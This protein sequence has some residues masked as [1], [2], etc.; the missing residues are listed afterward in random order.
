MKFRYFVGIDVAKATL[1]I[2]VL[3]EDGSAWQEHIDN[4]TASIKE[5]LRLLQQDLKAG[6]KNTLFCLE[7]SGPYTGHLIGE[8]LRRKASLWVESALQIKRSLG[9]QRGKNDKIDALRIAQ[10]ASLKRASF[11]PFCP[12]REVMIRLQQ[13]SGLKHRLQQAIGS[14]Q[15]PIGEH[16]AFQPGHLIKK[17]QAHCTASLEAL[18]ND[19]KAVEAAMLEEVRWDERLFRLYQVATSVRG[20][21]PAVAIEL[22][23]ATN[24][25]LKFSSAKKFACYSGLAPFEHS[26]GTSVRGGS[27]VSKLANKKVKSLL[28]LPALAVVKYPGE[29]RDYYLRKVAEGHPKMSVLNAVKNKIITRVFTCV[30]EDRLYRKEYKRPGVPNREKPSG[31]NNEPDA[32]Q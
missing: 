15:K 18:K 7:H 5:W 26:S 32:R 2:A 25:F 1:D 30:R 29:L 16:A 8:L 14:L 22:L 13:L 31:C 19:L 4:T 28:Y 10:Y 27:R 6:G 11:Q 3:Q 17:L 12:Q 21:G 20:I 24:E 9:I 23:I